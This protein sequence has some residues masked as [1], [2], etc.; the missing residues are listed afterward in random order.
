MCVYVCWWVCAPTHGEEEYLTVVIYYKL[1]N[2]LQ[3]FSGTFD[4]LLG[5]A[6]KLPLL[7]SN[8]NR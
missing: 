5:I 3:L 1:M 4:W 6:L 7:M 2:K 8:D